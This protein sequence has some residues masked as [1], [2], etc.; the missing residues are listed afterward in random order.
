M[1]VQLGISHLLN[2]AGGDNRGGMLTGSGKVKPDQDK[3]L[4]KNIIYKELP[5]KVSRGSQTY[6][7]CLTTLT[8]LLVDRTPKMK[9]L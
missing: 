6:P 7:T 9:I 4:Q 8:Y 3:L 1:L 2:C 5:L